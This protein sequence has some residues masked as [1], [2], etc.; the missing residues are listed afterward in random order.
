ML[1]TP[2]TFL[3]TGWSSIHGSCLFL[4]MPVLHQP[5]CLHPVAAALIHGSGSCLP[6][7]PPSP[8]N[9]VA[10]PFA[11][12]LLL[13]EPEPLP[14]VAH[15]RLLCPSPLPHSAHLLQPSPP[16]PCPQLFNRGKRACSASARAWPFF[17][18]S[19]VTCTQS[20]RAAL[21]AATRA[22]N[23]ARIAFAFATGSSIVG[24]AGGGG[25]GGG[26]GGDGSAA[27]D[28]EMD[29]VTGVS[30]A[31]APSATAFF[32]AACSRATASL[33]TGRHDAITGTLTP[34]SRAAGPDR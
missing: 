4:F 9:S 11:S 27:S 10:R 32:A 21:S 31:A 24:V 20:S 29:S 23:A 34:A 22:S 33:S 6:H 12:R 25:G 5:P 13:L 18:S 1:L 28:A 3:H 26:G 14:W 17:F 30:S 15:V 19:I 2:A 8:P 7:Q 16:L